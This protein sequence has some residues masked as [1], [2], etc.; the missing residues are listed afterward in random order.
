MILAPRLT[1]SSMPLITQLVKPSPLVSSTLTDSRLA[2]QPTDA[3]PMPL[4]V[5]AAGDAGDFG[6][7]LAVAVV[8]VGDVDARR[9][10]SA[11]GRDACVSTPES[12]MAMVTPSP[13]ERSHAL[14]APTWPAGTTAA[15]PPLQDVT[16]GSFGMNRGVHDAVGRAPT[17]RPQAADRRAASA[18][19]AQPFGPD[20]LAT[21]AI[22]DARDRGPRR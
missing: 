21:E 16:H 15:C 11:R 2:F 1:A 14:G 13:C 20:G 10:P 22:D 12:R 9:R 6:A 17:R 18:S 4:L 8:H 7:V 5:A 3:T 19:P